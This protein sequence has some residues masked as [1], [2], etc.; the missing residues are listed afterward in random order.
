MD[1][2]LHDRGLRN[3]GFARTRFLGQA[4]LPGAKFKEAPG[5][6]APSSAAT[7]ASSR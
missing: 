5:S 2:K 1:L 7:R 3:A 4:S 6:T